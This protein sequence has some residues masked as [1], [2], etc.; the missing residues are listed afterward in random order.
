MTA[1]APG[2]LAPLRSALDG[3][4][5]PRYWF[6]RDDDAGWA[7]EQLAALTA[8]FCDAGALLDV[9]AIPAAVSPHLGA[10]L[11][12][13]I[14]SGVVAVH[15]HG[16]A[17]I[18]H[19]PG[20][21]RCEFGS[22]RPISDQLHDLAHGRAVLSDL[23]EGRAEPMFTPPWNRCGDVTVQLLAELGFTALSCDHT[24]PRRPA[25]GVIEVPVR[26][27]WARCWR[28]GGA[29]LVGHEL[30]AAVIESDASVP[31]P[32][33]PAAGLGVMVHH[34]TLC[35]E[36]LDALRALLAVLRDHPAAPLTSMGALVADRSAAV[37]RQAAAATPTGVAH[38]AER[39][40]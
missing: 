40:Q 34:A 31:R 17:H 7:D 37:S 5:G 8:V 28:E 36:E 12:R 6:F 30:A 35:S 4:G 33:E 22:S 24:A 9:A 27:D 2:W 25:V 39:T 20:G 3:P 15:Q 19:E 26:V 32:A 38:S 14:E 16:W 23:L 10:A 13:L 18:N 29:G 11:R 1:A 21:R